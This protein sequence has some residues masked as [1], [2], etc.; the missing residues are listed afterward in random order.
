MPTKVVGDLKLEACDPGGLLP[1]EHRAVVISEP[2]AASGVSLTYSTEW[3]DGRLDRPVWNADALGLGGWALDVLQRYDPERG[4]LLS[5]DG[6]WRFAVAV[7]IGERERAVPTYDGL[8]YYVFDSGWRHVRTVDSTTGATLLSFTYDDAGRLSGIS[9]PGGG[10]PVALTVQRGP[11]GSLRSLASSNGIGTIANVNGDG[12]LA[13]VGRPDGTILAVSYLEHGLV[14]NWQTTGRGVVQYAWDATGRLTKAT[15]PD[16]VWRQI[17]TESADG[18]STITVT[19]PDGG[20]ATLRSEHDG[21]VIHR[22]F[23]DTDRTVTQL[24]TNADGS[25]RLEEADGTTT[26]FG[27]TPHP[28]WALAAPVL[29]PIIETR[30]HGTAYRVETTTTMAT[31]SPAPAGGA[32]ETTT[33]IDGQ[34]WVDAYDPASRSATRTDPEGRKATQTFDADGRVIAQRLPGQPPVTF[35]YD[36]TGL[37][38]STVVGEG[39]TAATTSYT[40]ADGTVTELRPDGTTI[41]S[42]LD[43]FGRLRRAA[44]SEEHVAFER[45][46]GGRVLQ[47]RTGTHAATSFGYS[48]AGRETAFLPPAVGDDAWYEITTYTPA[49][50]VATISDPF[51][52][53]VEIEYD[54]AGRATSWTFD[55]GTSSTTYDGSSGLLASNASPDGVTTAFAY[56]GWVQ[57][58][59]AWSGPVDGD[60]RATVNNLLQPTAI[61]INGGSG[62]PLGYDGAGLLAS[63]GG[64]RIERDP[65]TGLPTR[66]ILGDVVTIY[67]HDASMRLVA[68]TT[69]SAGRA[70]L[71]VRYTRDLLGRVTRVDRTDAAARLSV[72]SYGYDATN[73]LTAYQRDAM[74]TT[75]AYDASGNRTGVTRGTS[76][77]TETFDDRDRLVERA[78]QA[79]RFSPDGTLLERIGPKGTT[80]YEFDDL[81]ALR[82]VV[83]PGGRRIDYVIDAGGRRIGRMVDG[84]LTDGYLYGV[85]D[86]IVAW[87]D[88]AG[89][90]RAQFAYDDDG[91]LA[92]V[93]R[94]GRELLVVT[95]QLGGPIALLDG[96]SGKVIATVAYDAWG[97]A[98]GDTPSDILP[99][100]FAGG[101]V[102]PDTGLVHFGARDYDPAAGRWT[103]PDPLRYGGGDTNLYRYANG[104]PVNVTDPSGTTACTPGACGTFAGRAASARPLPIGGGHRSGGKTGGSHPYHDHGPRQMPP[105]PPK[106]GNGLPPSKFPTNDQQ[107]IH[108]G[109]PGFYRPPTGNG[110]VGKWK[111]SFTTCVGSV[112]LRKTPDGPEL[113]R[114]RAP[115]GPNAQCIMLCSPPIPGVR[116]EGEC[117]LV[118]Q[119]NDPEGNDGFS[120][121]GY[122]SYGE[123]HLVTADGGRV[124]FQAA[125]EF[126]IA[127]SADGAFEIQA[128]YEPSRVVH[129]VTMTTALTMRV[130]PDRVAIYRDPDTGDPSRALVING[131]AIDRAQYS[132]TLPGGGIVERLGADVRITWPD[133]SRLGAHLYAKFLNFSL[134]PADAVAAST[135]GLLGASDGDATNDLATRDGT[136]LDR[137]A[138]DFLDQLYGPFADSWRI[139]QVDS[140]FDYRAGETTETFQQIEVPTT[141]VTVADLDARARADAEALCRAMG[142]T[143]DPILT[144]CIFDVGMTGD[145]SFA[146]SAATVAASIERASTPSLDLGTGIER[147]QPVGGS[148]LAGAVDRYHFTAAAGDIVYLDAEGAC[149]ANVDWRLVRPN[150]A[151]ATFADACTD[152]A[153]W[154]LPEAGEWRIEVYSDD[155]SAGP[156]S[157][158]VLT[159]APPQE[160]AIVPGGSARGTTT[161]P[162]EWHSYRLAAKA[163]DVVYLDATGDCSSPMSWRLLQPDGSLTTFARTCIDLG[164]RVL[165]IAGDWVIEVFADGPEAGSYAFRVIGAPATRQGDVAV[166]E[167]VADATTRIGEWHR[168]SLTAK[169][170]QVVY[171]DALGQCRDGLSWQ[172]LRPDGGLKTFAKTCDDLGRWVLDV[173]GDWSI[174]VY[175]PELATGAY[176]FKVIGAPAVKTAALR[177]GTK[178]SGT[179]GSVGEWHRYTLAAKAGQKIVIDAQGD[180]IDELWWR[181]LKPDGQLTTFAKSCTDS[182]VRM[183]DVAGDWVIEVY[184]DTLATGPYAFTVRPG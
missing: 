25:M 148:L 101:L 176:S 143:S 168:Y 32:W 165:D 57:T 88:G 2:V 94:D 89:D 108:R 39:A 62:L 106:E 6:S 24:D 20:I 73:R 37:L 84:V 142:V 65:Q 109:D 70:A 5:G 115:G 151:L 128:R 28:R 69:T 174:E 124:D 107:E 134:A 147:E 156:Y 137:E 50:Q 76:T 140:L 19:D 121:I 61:A 10:S 162:G 150:G 161:A 46:P 30:P 33:T 11:D 136:V 127:K 80:T 85:D 68:T 182:D 172:L 178:V 86:A 102:D 60:V 40:F 93:R 111:N 53:H 22:T 83:L 42:V 3:A 17:A 153:R 130:G 35:A 95:D 64:L 167:T 34:H 171:L 139:A 177:V 97:N 48:E 119:G 113:Y 159:V 14:A 131:K 56:D 104:D 23:T 169:K 74:S 43:G 66:S 29:T 110:G 163:G 117:F 36:P 59:I 41:I 44:T 63:I 72:S 16:G 8:R 98:I 141:N 38:A 112:C 79:Y 4:V 15:D 49:G 114:G 91:Q 1:C 31:G 132:T 54:D 116:N 118:C 82:S 170:G 158:R 181:L 152:M 92:L 13:A 12:M 166:G 52:R 138:A 67:E 144:D 157:F 18:S 100:G 133:G 78:D 126:V 149:G 155:A 27:A 154:V 90:V 55:E 129:T 9:G 179:I 71:T 180:C 183:L 58:G 75:Y 135:V 26:T 184:S 51:A 21:D 87:T 145:P 175:A 146:G 123:P 164:R 96:G 99:L 81:G 45:E 120:C 47:L 173:A 7:D 125:G 105:P 77:T 103:A 122:C 160:Q